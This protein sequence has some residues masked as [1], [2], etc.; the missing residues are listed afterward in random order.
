MASYATLRA[1]AFVLAVPDAPATARWWVTRL[2]FQQ[3]L[4]AP[5][6]VFV[7][8]GPIAIRLASQPGAPA[9]IGEQPFFAF[10]EVDDID[11]FHAEIVERGAKPGKDILEGPTTLPTGL[12]EMSVQTP[13]GH[14]ILFSQRTTSSRWQ[15]F[16]PGQNLRR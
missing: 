2:G 5:G 9:V 10:I 1:A 12:R 4:E 7:E 6:W 3:T 16:V 13:D 8:R 15:A 14:R 11:A